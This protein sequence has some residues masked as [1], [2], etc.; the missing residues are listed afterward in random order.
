MERHRRAIPVHVIVHPDPGL[1]GAAVARE[2][3]AP[4]PPLTR[5]CPRDREHDALTDRVDNDRGDLLDLWRRRFGYTPAHPFPLGPRSVR[6]ARAC[7][8]RHRVRATGRDDRAVL[9]VDSA[10]VPLLVEK[11]DQ[12]VQWHASTGSVL[13]SPRSSFWI[14]F[15]IVVYMHPF[16]CVVGLLGPSSRWCSSRCTSWR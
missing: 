1:L 7:A 15:N 2:A 10:L 14:V 12:E 6:H 4:R 5:A 16:G 8:R 13:M 9:P 3:R 11:T